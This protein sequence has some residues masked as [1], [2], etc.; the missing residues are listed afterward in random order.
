MQTG[1]R[2]ALC[3]LAILLLAA[4]ASAA[5]QDI[6]HQDHRQ[7]AQLLF[8]P[9][10][11]A[12]AG[13]AGSAL[14]ERFVAEHRGLLGI[15]A[16]G[17][18]VYRGAQSS[19]LG[20]H[21]RFQQELGG[22]AIE[23]AELIVSVAI[24]D[25][26]VYRVFNNVEPISGA[27]I[28]QPAFDEDAAYDIAWA[29]L[30]PTGALLSAPAIRLV[31][32]P[33]GAALRLN[34]IVQLELASPYGGWELRIDASS[35]EI[36]DLRDARIYRHDQG[37]VSQTPAARIAAQSGAVLDRRQ[38]FAEFAIGS[39]AADE[40]GVGERA[41]G[42]GVMFDPD[43]RA[44]LL[45]DN[46]QDNSPA[47]AFAAAY[48]TRDLL[49]IQFSGGLY[50]VTGPW[51][52]IMNW[53]PPATP[54]S[55]TADGNWTATRGNN[56]MNDAMTYFQID[57]NNRYMQGLGFV[58]PMAIQDGPI[59]TDTDGA[60]GADNSYYYSGTN[61]M[62]FGHGCVDDS[63][64]SDVMLHEYGHA[65]NYDINGSWGGGDMGAI[66]EGFGDYWAGSYS[67]STP[68]GEIYHPEWVFSWDG[69]GTGNQCWS[70]RILDAF[71][72]V[73]VHTTNYG[74]HQSIPGG[75]ISDELWSTPCFQSLITLMAGGETRESCDRII[76]ES[77]FG[78]GG[79]LKMRAMANAIIATAGL[80]E[81]AG[82]HAQVY[83]EKFA[84]HNIV[85]VPFVSLS[86]GD[87]AF[88]QAG[89]NGAPD[90]GESVHMVVNVNNVGTL[91]A[92]GV[93]AVLSCADPLVTVTTA[94]ADYPDLPAGGGGA[95]LSDFVVAF[96]PAIGCGD[97]VDL[98][99][100]VSFANERNVT[101]VPFQIQTG[102]KVWASQA[103][104]PNVAIPDNVTGGVTSTISFSGTGLTV[105][106]EF[107]VDVNVSHADVGDL[108]LKLTAPSGTWIYLYYRQFPG[109]V[110]LV[111]NFPGD[112]PPY[113]PLSN[114]NG[115]PLDGTWTLN[116]SDIAAGDTGT[117]VSWGINE[118]IGIECQQLVAGP[119][120]P[121]FADFALHQNRPNPFNPSTEIRFEIPG[122]GSA[123]DLA[124]YDIAGR[125]VAGL[126]S[127]FVAGGSHSVVWRGRDDAGRSVGSGV[128]FYRL[129]AD[130]FVESRKLLLLK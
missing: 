37:F 61:R 106:D 31:L 23:G 96:D 110:N 125:R 40:R 111:G 16:P 76:L 75:Y 49:D 67:Y 101:I 45:N 78:L 55:T 68:N 105:S 57:Q 121:V 130:G 27:G 17:S 10:W 5:P 115:Q 36:V 88:S 11:Q 85:D 22:L 64:D 95:N 124:V 99:L 103:A 4:L 94:N 21:H 82:P 56:A 93:S 117:L 33:E 113:M 97:L 6:F 80:L 44:T 15:D 43:P 92:V 90:P 79:G 102:L 7:S 84:W 86:A 24:V 83:T 127:G 20:T 63:E 2:S 48:F 108:R 69:H 50:R 66:G 3:A 100:T 39:G 128:Y 120:T 29:R 123:I 47:G 109:Q 9:A 53:D 129:E 73:Y 8:E 34:Y 18:L 116:A 32:T 52:N 114:F 65:I 25:G 72:A 70:G 112:Y 60:N 118:L 104:S 19:L 89:P 1:T 62:A 13:V 81:P 12:P 42:T 71:G 77:Q 28:A 122:E 35:G 98:L 58:G 91:G 30:A 46:L 54:P 38:A 126:A 26:R 14:A 119:A 51:V 107:N 59:G 41:Q 74:A 87:V